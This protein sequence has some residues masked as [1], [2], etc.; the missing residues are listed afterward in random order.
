MARVLVVDD[1]REIVDILREY[2]SRKGYAVS[3]AYDGLEAIQKLKEERPHVVLL[4]IKMPKM[5]GLEV[6]R[7]MR[8]LDQ[9]VGVIMI[10]G[11][12]DEET[13]RAALTLGA[14]D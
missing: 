8:K 2:L 1:E 3:A 5:N 13:G 10:T 11:V 9:E 12:L 14:F 6:L 7:Q 4:D